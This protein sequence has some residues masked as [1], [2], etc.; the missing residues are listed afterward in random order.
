NDSAPMIVRITRAK[1]GHR[2]APQM[3]RPIP[4]GVGL[5]Y[6]AFLIVDRRRYENT[7]SGRE[8]VQANI[9]TTYKLSAA[10]S[11]AF[12]AVR[13]SIACT[14]AHRRKW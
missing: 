13:T 2:Q 8:S 14:P 7:P 5:F 3:K 12:N 9:G 4:K 6:L 10:T 1:V 11:A